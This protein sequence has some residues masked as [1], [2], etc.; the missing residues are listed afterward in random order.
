MTAI[1]KLEE[2]YITKRDFMCTCNEEASAKCDRVMEEVLKDLTTKHK[3]CTRSNLLSQV[4]YN[5]QWGL[6]EQGEAHYVGSIDGIGCDMWC[7][8]SAGVAV[9][10]KE[11]GKYVEI[12]GMWVQCD[13]VEHG[14]ARAWQL[15][16]EIVEE[17]RNK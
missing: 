5:L 6:G 13:E 12:G 10:D 16:N 17:H 8:I 11:K 15:A 3:E 9:M 2:G 4:V 1:E 7:G 14:I